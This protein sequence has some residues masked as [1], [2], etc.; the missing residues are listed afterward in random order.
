MVSIIAGMFFFDFGVDEYADERL[1]SPG[2]RASYQPD[3]YWEVEVF[4][5]LYR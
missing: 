2:I 1:A 5:Q 4:A 3:P